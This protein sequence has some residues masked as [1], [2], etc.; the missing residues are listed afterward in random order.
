MKSL[1]NIQL[2]IVLLSVTTVA[3][4]QSD[5]AKIRL[6]NGNKIEGEVIEMVS[7]DYIKLR[8]IQ[9]EEITIPFDQIYKFK[10]NSYSYQSFADQRNGY[11]NYTSIGFTFISTGG[12]GGWEGLDWNLHTLNGYRIN[13]NY[14]IGIGVGIDRYLEISAAPVYLGTRV[15]IGKKH[16]VPTLFANVGYSPLWVKNSNEEWSN[17]VNIRGGAYWELG[18]GLT[19]RNIHSNF[20]LNLAYKHQSSEIE[21]ANIGWWDSQG[22]DTIEKHQFRNITFTFGMTF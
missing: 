15:D 22:F 5:V 7:D 4:S 6:K 19:F 17:I 3:Y 1:L 21:Y 8:I 9:G 18:A 2:S 10:N 20:S 14:K 13:S 11:F 16:V 12:N